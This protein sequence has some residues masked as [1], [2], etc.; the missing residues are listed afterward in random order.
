MGS[1]CLL[2]LPCVHY[3]GVQRMV[4]VVNVFRNFVLCIAVAMSDLAHD[5]NAIHVRDKTLTPY[6]TWIFSDI[7]VM[8]VKLQIEVSLASLLFQ[9]SYPDAVSS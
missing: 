9:E 2:G 7:L 4:L 6:N 5:V 8:P 3:H 1:T